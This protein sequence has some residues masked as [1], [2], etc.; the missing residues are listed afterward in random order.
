MVFNNSILLNNKVSVVLLTPSGHLITVSVP[1][2]LLLRQV[3]L[4]VYVRNV[5]TSYIAY[6]YNYPVCMYTHSHEVEGNEITQ[7]LLAMQ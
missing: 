4:Y 2:H 6:M 5:Y 3:F 7:I 1:F